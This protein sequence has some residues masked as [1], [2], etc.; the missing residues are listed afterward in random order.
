[1]VTEQR[2]D[3][4]QHRLINW[5]AA[6]WAGIGAGIVFMVLEMIMVPLFGGG[7]AWG[8]PS[9]IAA[10]VMGQGVLPAP[11]TPPTFD[12]LVL[13]VALIVHLILSIIYAVILGFI[14]QRF[15][16]GLTLL[17]GAVFGLA[18][19][20]VNFYGFTAVFPWFANA[21]N[22]ITI[23]THISFG[24]VAAAV[25]KGIERPRATAV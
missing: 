25:Y 18:L 17:I 12:F 11:G 1:M 4:F 5:R 10:I 14:I 7:S 2:R 24:L 16:I 3:N 19:Y 23:F 13:M 15:D 20:L 9:L 21:R 6:V 22:W 8:P